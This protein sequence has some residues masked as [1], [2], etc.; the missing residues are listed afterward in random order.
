MRIN[1]ILRKEIRRNV[2]SLLAPK[3][4]MTGVLHEILQSRQVSDG[5]EIF[6]LHSYMDERKGALLTRVFERIRPTTSLEVGF[7]YGISTLFIGDAL[8]KIN[9]PVRHIVI[10]PFQST[11]WN[12]IGLKNVERAG[13]GKFVDLHEEKSELVLP[14]LLAQNTVL[15]AALIDGWHTFDHA[16]VDFFYINKMLQV[17]GIIV[18]DDTSWPSV[19]RLV[20]HILT[21]G[22]YRV[23][24]TPDPPV[25]VAWCLPFIRRMAYYVRLRRSKWPSAMALQKISP[26]ER[27][28]DWYRSF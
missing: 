19:G 22:C 1:S 21:Y 11:D 25:V 27:N 2:K 3:H 8:S 20:N 13:Y 17:G 16:L 24:A 23:F 9:Q 10:D 14:Q 15:D 6:P 18:L 28:F 12:G 4:R 5:Q 26:D 7:A